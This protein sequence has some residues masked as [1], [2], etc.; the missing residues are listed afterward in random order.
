MEKDLGDYRKS[1]EKGVLLETAIS[2]NPMELFQKWFHEVDTHFQQD[3]T[4]A[5]TLSTLG[6]DGYPKNR[7]VLLKKYDFEGFIFY[8]NYESE[9]GKAMD[10]NPNV[11]L[12]F[13]WAAAERHAKVVHIVTQVPTNNIFGNFTKNERNYH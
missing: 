3:E 6:L 4:N 10:V 5:M 9:K 7:V 2:D 12:S 13:H 1:Y 8:T 11:C